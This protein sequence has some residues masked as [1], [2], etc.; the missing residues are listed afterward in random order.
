MAET[1]YK[2]IYM[3]KCPVCGTETKSA[4]SMCA[5]IINTFYRF[6]A[7]WNWMADRGIKLPDVVGTYKPLMEVVE[8]ECKLTKYREKE[9]TVKVLKPEKDK[10]VVIKGHKPKKDKVL[11]VKRHK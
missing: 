7:H 8:S 2:T 5:H 3:Y 6:E 4:A 9:I 1:R 11:V 10:V